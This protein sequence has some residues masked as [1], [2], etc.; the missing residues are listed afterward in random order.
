M[1][2][3]PFISSIRCTTLIKSVS[4]SL[5]YGIVSRPTC[6]PIKSG[7]LRI[8]ETGLIKGL[9]FRGLNAISC[10]C[11]STTDTRSE[12]DFMRVKLGFF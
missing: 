8:S 1:F 11:P 3:Y 12:T 5:R 7:V 9:R 6:R 4:Y 2:F 10:R